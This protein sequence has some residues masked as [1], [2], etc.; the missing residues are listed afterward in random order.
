[1]VTLESW[2]DADE[3][4]ELCNSAGDIAFDAIKGY[5]DAR[6]LPAPATNVEC[7]SRAA[8]IA[9]ARRKGW[10]YPAVDRN[11]PAGELAKIVL[12][13]LGFQVRSGSIGFDATVCPINATSPVL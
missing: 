1:M 5:Y 9:F 13:E 4:R 8:G 10:T 12:N 2:L 7:Q 11:D 3:N 6:D